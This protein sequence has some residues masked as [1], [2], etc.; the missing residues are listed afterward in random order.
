MTVGQS[1]SALPGYIRR[2]LVLLSL[3]RHRPRCQKHFRSK[4]HWVLAYFDFGSGL[5]WICQRRKATTAQMAS[6][7]PNGHAPWRNP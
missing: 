3:A 1:M 5:I 7:T 4:H 6:T 2:Q